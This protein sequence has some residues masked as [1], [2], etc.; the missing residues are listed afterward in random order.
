MMI[1]M[2]RN[3][4]YCMLSIYNYKLYIE[5]FICSRFDNPRPKDSFYAVYASDE[6]PKTLN[7]TISGKNCENSEICF[8]VSKEPNECYV[9]FS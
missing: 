3:V 1:H 5:I 7:L 9:S 2:L 8:L 6:G 4:A